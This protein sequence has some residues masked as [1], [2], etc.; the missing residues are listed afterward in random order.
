MEP[1]MRILLAFALLSCLPPSATFA[2]P[3]PPSTTKAD[4]GPAMIRVATVV[5]RVERDGHDIRLYEG[6]RLL[7]LPWFSEL[8]LA[9]PVNPGLRFDSLLGFSVGLVPA[10]KPPKQWALYTNVVGVGGDART[11]ADNV[12]RLKKVIVC[13]PQH[14]VEM[15]MDGWVYR[16]KAGQVLLVLG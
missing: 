13:T 7:D 10:A 4:V 1:I 16:L 12:F 9:T 11:L 3:P 8:A 14:A 6:G 15:R 5:E 2:Q